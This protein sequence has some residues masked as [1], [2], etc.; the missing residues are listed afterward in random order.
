MLSPDFFSLITAKTLLKM[1]FIL[2]FDT[3]SGGPA[4]LDPKGG[5]VI[6]TIRNIFSKNRAWG[7]GVGS[8]L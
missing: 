1:V 6:I 7:G 4:I 5:L 3:M 8:R 2:D